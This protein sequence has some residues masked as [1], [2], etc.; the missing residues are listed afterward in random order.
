[1]A[2]PIDTPNLIAIHDKLVEAWALA[3]P[4]VEVP[5]E[6]VLQTLG[7][8]I[9]VIGGQASDIPTAK[10]VQLLVAA[11]KNAAEWRALERGDID[12]LARMPGDDGSV[13]GNP[14]EVAKEWEAAAIAF[15]AATG[16]P[17]VAKRG[18]PTGD[19]PPATDA[20]IIK[21]IYEQVVAG[22]ERAFPGEAPDDAVLQTVTAM[23]LVMG[24][25]TDFTAA[26]AASGLR[27][28]RA[29]GAAWDAASRGDVD[30]LMRVQVEGTS[31]PNPDREGTA[32]AAAAAAVADATGKP[33]VVR[34]GLT[35]LGDDASRTKWGLWIG[36]GILAVTVAGFW[37]VLA[38]P[39]RQAGAGALAGASNPTPKGGRYKVRFEPGVVDGFVAVAV[40]LYGEGYV[41]DEA[42]S[43]IEFTAGELRKFEEFLE[44]ARNDPEMRLEEDGAVEAAH[45]DSALES[46]RATLAGAS[47]PTGRLAARRTTQRGES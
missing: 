42:G 31:S 43:T 20:Q 22:W 10:L 26:Q 47:N 1:V 46:V 24:A 30:A 15:A 13:A 39:P 11:R 18:V 44:H 12:T 35:P 23:V 7:A 5:D 2:D 45:I 17:W 19:G 6:A 25:G 36:G 34:R 37:F 27:K 3:V 29:N 32:L 21:G 33:W 38:H 40:E 9:V 4:D 14:E 16:Q 41:Y 28:L 8:G